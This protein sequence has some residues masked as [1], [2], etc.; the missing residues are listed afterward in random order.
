MHIQ[1][2]V[3]QVDSPFVFRFNLKNHRDCCFNVCL[4]VCVFIFSDSSN[5]HQL[6][7]CL[8]LSSMYYMYLEIYFYLNKFKYS[9]PAP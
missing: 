9:F 5:S 1:K 2:Y 6:K 7:I 3:Y 4:F 8:R